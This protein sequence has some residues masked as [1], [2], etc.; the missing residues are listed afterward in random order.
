MPKP[1]KSKSKILVKL[2]TKVSTMD[3]L[4]ELFES[5]AHETRRGNIEN[6]IKIYEEILEP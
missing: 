2:I 4:A 5:A 6:V 1:R 3:K